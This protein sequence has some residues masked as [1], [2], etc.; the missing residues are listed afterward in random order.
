VHWFESEQHWILQ[1]LWG[2][3]SG[4]WRGG[5][6]SLRAVSVLRTRK[7]SNWRICRRKETHQSFPFTDMNIT[8]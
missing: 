7:R 5:S 3:G 1:L 4:S 8:I 6:R 2:V